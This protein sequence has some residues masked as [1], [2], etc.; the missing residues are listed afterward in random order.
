MPPA[1]ATASTGDDV[2]RKTA[3][4]AVAATLVA[5]P[6]SDATVD[7]TLLAQG[8]LVGETCV[9]D[10]TV[11]LPGGHRAR[12]DDDC[13]LWM[14]PVDSGEPPL[15]VLDAAP[16][17]SDRLP[18]SMTGNPDDASS[19]GVPALPGVPHLAAVPVGTYTRHTAHV[20]QTFYDE[21]GRPMY[22]DYQTFDFRRR[23]ATGALTPPVPGWAG[24]E[25]P[26]TPPGQPDPRDPATYLVAGPYDADVRLCWT[27]LRSTTSTL[28]SFTTGGWYETWART[29]PLGVPSVRRD[30]RKIVGTF[31]TRDTGFDRAASGCD[32]GGL[33]VGW[34]RDCL[35][36]ETVS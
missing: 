19:L 29:P 20:E 7:E 32:V 11:M 18:K 25:T 26:P 31:V 14:S 6:Q 24:C 4:L 34:S 21:A 2:F 36:E 5:A 28:L 16:P 27:D 22:H 30:F 23:A 15:T 10:T 12:A 13:A 33:L 17:G 1:T 3:T 8:R 9:F 35:V